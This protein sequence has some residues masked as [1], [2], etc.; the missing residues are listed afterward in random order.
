M[1]SHIAAS[2]EAFRLRVA[3]GTW[4]PTKLHS[5]SGQLLHEAGSAV[6][7]KVPSKK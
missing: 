5:Y 2:E 7:L 1:P 6:T 3:A 4:E